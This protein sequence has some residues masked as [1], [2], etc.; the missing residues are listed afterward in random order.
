MVQDHLGNTFES[1]TDMCQHWGITMAAYQTRHKKMS[2]EQTLTLPLKQRYKQCTDHKG[3]QFDTIKDMC[4]YWN[5]S[6]KLFQ[7]R[8]SNG[9]SLEQALTLKSGDIPRYEIND[10]LGNTF[11][12]KRAMCKHYKIPLGTYDKRIAKGYTIEEALTKSNLS[13]Q[14]H[15]GKTF[16]STK[17]LCDYYK[18]SITTFMRRKSQN[19]TIEECIFGKH[20]PKI[21]DHLGNE[22]DDVQSM[23][24]YHGVSRNTYVSR[25]S[26]GKSLEECLANYQP[27]SQTIKD[28]LGN[29]YKSIVSMCKAYNID[30][31]LYRARRA[32]NW[33]LEKALTQPRKNNTIIDH[34]GNE[35]NTITELCDYWNA[36]ET[37]FAARYHAGNHS[38]STSL[39]TSMPLVHINT[40]DVHISKN[41]IISKHIY[42]KYYLCIIDGQEIVQHL[43]AI[44]E[45]ALNVQKQTN[46]KTI[47][48]LGHANTIN[49]FINQQYCLCTIDG[50]EIIQHI[51]TITQE[52]SQPD[53][54][55]S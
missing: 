52:Y 10:H 8:I 50:K 37:V 31:N 4:V 39:C 9:I 32:Q 26:M 2:L 46:L 16:T 41:Y 6:P 29:E 43:N 38:I 24:D 42:N 51:S 30:P 36:S 35:F 27:R 44:I 7:S 22:F 13:V 3:N 15:L 20:K 53:R 33:S 21:H 11:S 18:I 40:Y 23:C 19:L 17:E 48:S 45:Y 47:P 49:R 28:H 5:I 25:K 14:D 1:I 12:S 54:R 34:K 55:T